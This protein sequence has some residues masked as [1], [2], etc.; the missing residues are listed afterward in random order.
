MRSTGL[1]LAVKA[2]PKRKLKGYEHELEQEVQTWS[3]L[4]GSLNAIT[5]YETFEDAINVYL[6]MEVCNGGDLY[7]VSEVQFVPS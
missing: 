2:I 1:N 3:Y 6:V 4:A 5:L 7:H